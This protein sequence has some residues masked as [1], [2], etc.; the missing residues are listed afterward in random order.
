[1][2]DI[3]QPD[4]LKSVFQNNN[5]FFMIDYNAE[6]DEILINLREGQYSNYS[7][8]LM[9]LKLD[10]LKTRKQVAL[11]QTQLKTLHQAPLNM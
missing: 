8:S 6:K 4:Q 1:M 7:Y 10:T 9:V 3:S 11:K 2:G 5:S